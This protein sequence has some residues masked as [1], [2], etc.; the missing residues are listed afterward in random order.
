MLE[1]GYY[2]NYEFMINV[3]HIATVWKL[4]VILLILQMQSSF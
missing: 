1:K 2:F 3:H 4:Q